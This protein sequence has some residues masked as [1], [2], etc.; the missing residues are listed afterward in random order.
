MVLWGL[1]E[2]RDELKTPSILIQAVLLIQDHGLKIQSSQGWA[3]SE[4]SDLRTVLVGRW[5]EGALGH[6]CRF[7]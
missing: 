7:N 6:L 4:A 3:E 5:K 2:E 1:H